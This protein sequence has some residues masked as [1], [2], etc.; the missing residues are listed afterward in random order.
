VDTQEKAVLVGFLEKAVAVAAETLGRQGAEAVVILVLVAAVAAVVETGDQQGAEAVEI[1][2]L[3]ASVAVAVETSGQQETEAVEIL[4]LVGAVAVAVETWGQ[5]GADAMQILASVV[6]VVEKIGALVET[7]GVA[8]RDQAQEEEGQVL[9]TLGAPAMAGTTPG[10]EVEV[11]S[12]VP[13]ME[14]GM[15]LNEQAGSEAH[16]ASRLTLSLRP[17]N[18][19]RIS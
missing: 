14:A 3:M 11:A 9:Q 13:G 6:A 7:P 17:C 1:L 4:A 5:Q 12:E 19:Q 15:G 2:A 18:A 8:A 16:R 10:V